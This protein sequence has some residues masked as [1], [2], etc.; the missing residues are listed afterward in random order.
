ARHPTS[1]GTAALLIERGRDRR[2]LEVV[3]AREGSAALQI[4]QRRIERVADPARRG[5][6]PALPRP[7]RA[8]AVRTSAFVLQI[9]PGGVA[10]DSDH[11][12]SDLIIESDLAAEHGGVAG[13]CERAIAEPPIAI[14]EAGA[15]VAADIK[16]APIIG[17]DEGRRLRRD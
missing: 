17:C 8:D 14:G 16:P 6:K 5:R 12:P 1:P 4:E 7:T 11:P 9:A 15:E 2:G 13:F 10:F 3:C